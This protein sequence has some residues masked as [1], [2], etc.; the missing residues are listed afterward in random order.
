[1]AFLASDV[2]VIGGPLRR[3]VDQDLLA[4]AGPGVDEG[5]RIAGVTAEA[6][7]ALTLLD[8]H[9]SKRRAGRC[10]LQPKDAEHQQRGSEGNPSASRSG[11][12]CAFKGRHAGR[13]A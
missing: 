13:R 10:R 2:A 4:L 12:G 11:V 6:P 7:E 5:L 8:G 9:G 3:Y 1:V